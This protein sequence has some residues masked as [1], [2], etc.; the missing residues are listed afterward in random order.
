MIIE[1][2]VLD[3][4]EV[5]IMTP[6]GGFILGRSQLNVDDLGDGDD[7]LQWQPYLGSATGCTFRR[8]G[9]RS[10]VVNTMDVGTLNV[11]LKNAGD[12]STEPNMIPGTPVRVRFVGSD[13]ESTLFTGAISDIDMNS[14][15]DKRTRSL[16]N[17]VTIQSV[18]AVQ[19]HANTTRYGAIAPAGYERWEA[20]IA[21]LS[22]SSSAPI[23][24]PTVDQ[25]IVRYAL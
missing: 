12:P 9:K 17:F 23:E 16:V 25:P 18:D 8:G 13:E 21:R 22:G 6:G 10:G 11:T 5:E 4:L 1:G 20:R 7:E 15:L 2:P 3:L 14:V 19:Q 24:V